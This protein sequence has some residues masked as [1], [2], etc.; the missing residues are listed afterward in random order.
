MNF[1][2]IISSSSLSPARSFCYNFKVTT[3]IYSQD[4]TS[5]QVHIE[6]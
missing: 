4:Q 1:I 5:S 6:T 2:S 3:A